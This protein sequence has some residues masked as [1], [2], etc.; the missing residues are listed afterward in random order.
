MKNSS[1]KTSVALTALLLT[2]ACASAF[3]GPEDAMSVAEQHP[4]AVDSQ[5]VTLTVDPDLTTDDLSSLDSARLKAFAT[6]YLRDG[7]GPL[8]ITAPSGS[9]SDRDSEEA[10]SDIRK[11]LH[12]A[13]VPWSALG[14]A[15]YRTGDATGKQVV[16]SYT[17]YVATAS[18]CGKW[19]GVRA[20]D[21]KNLR[22]PNFGCATMNNY[23]AMIADPHEL[24]ASAN[25]SEP[26]ATSRVR[27]IEAF[28]AG[29]VSVTETDDT[30]LQQVSEN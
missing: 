17:H 28:R 23:A 25:E 16:V 15:T 27:A 6:S 19:S 10:S 24:L 26:D 14:G 2:S 9:G 5:V 20:R 30:I 7:H 12:A 1:I 8:T 21:Y 4:I 13:G 11:A 22:M 29:E 18:E 3:N